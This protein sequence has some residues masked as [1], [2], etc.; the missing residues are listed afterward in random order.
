ML[1]PHPQQ[2]EGGWTLTALSMAYNCKVKE[3]ELLDGTLGENASLPRT[4]NNSIT[5]AKLLQNIE[6]GNSND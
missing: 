4:S 2:L 5:A 1:L 6:S 3:I